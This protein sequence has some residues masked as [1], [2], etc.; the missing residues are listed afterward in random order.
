[1]HHFG[2]WYTGRGLGAAEENGG[3]GRWGR[4]GG[5]VER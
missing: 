3:W 5:M 4:E 1:M 2:P